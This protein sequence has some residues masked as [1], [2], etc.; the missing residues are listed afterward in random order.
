VLQHRSERTA[1][2]NGLFRERNGGPIHYEEG[3]S[4]TGLFLGGA[5]AFTGAYLI[6]SALFRMPRHTP[7]SSQSSQ[8]R[9]K[10]KKTQ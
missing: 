4:A 7:P 1:E 5:M 6:L 2:L 3:Y 10:E 8:E 9:E